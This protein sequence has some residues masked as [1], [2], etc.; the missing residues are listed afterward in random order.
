MD[1]LF[2]L[3]LITIFIAAYG[4]LIY[5]FRIAEFVD[6]FVIEKMRSLFKTEGVGQMIPQ[7]LTRFLK[8]N[9]V[10][11]RVQTHP[12]A[13]TAPETAHAGHVPGKALVKVVMVHAYEKNIMMVLPS[14]RT[15]DLLKL[16]LTLG[17]NNLHIEGEQEFKNLFRDC[18]VGAMP[19]FGQLYQIPCY[20]DESLKA[21]PYL[22]FNAGNHTECI[23]ITTADFLRIVKGVV[24]DF[25]VE[26]KK[27]RE[28]VTACA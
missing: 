25:S 12:A 26:G 21:C 11:Y 6:F 10:P 1:A 22:Y 20:V 23:E 5:S 8:R 14:D 24:G 17:T 4:L 18:E 15:V 27:I 3:V 7:K 16:S 19:P 9:N 2:V 28:K 13:F